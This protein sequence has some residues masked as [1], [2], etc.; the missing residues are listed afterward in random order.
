MIHERFCL[1]SAD[2]TDAATKW[3]VKLHV[4]P[5]RDGEERLDTNSPVAIMQAQVTR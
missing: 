2:C 5:D 4:D 1:T 3:V